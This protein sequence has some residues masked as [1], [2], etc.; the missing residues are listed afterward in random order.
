M[1]LL[2][3]E[4]LYAFVVLKGAQ[5]RA[6]ACSGLVRNE[7]NGT[8]VEADGNGIGITRMFSSALLLNTRQARHAMLSPTYPHVLYMRPLSE[9]L[10][11]YLRSRILPVQTM[12]LPQS[13]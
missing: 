5:W 4:L 7:V 13:T 8:Q 11:V 1:L 6:L 2:Q 10:R 9:R 12:A 3:F